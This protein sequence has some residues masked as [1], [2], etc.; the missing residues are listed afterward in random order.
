MSSAREGFAR[1]LNMALDEAGVPPKHQGRQTETAK[2]FG[3]TQGSSRKWLVGDAYP[4][5]EKVR[6]IARKL[7][8]RVEWLLYG[9]GPMRSE[10]VEATVL[11]EEEAEIDEALLE[12][13]IE[14]VEDVLE[15]NGAA[16]LS[17][18][19]RVRIYVNVYK[20]AAAHHGEVDKAAVKM[21]LKLVA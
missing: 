14:T 8:V 13:V 1:R 9:D 3:V 20:F 16:H 15:E 21:A 7:K 17:H 12:K 19:A 4:D 5:V 2:L 10:G 11:H 18:H 6:D